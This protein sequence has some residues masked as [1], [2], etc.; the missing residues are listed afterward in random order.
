MGSLRKRVVTDLM[1]EVDGF[2]W[3]APEFANGLGFRWSG[4]DQVATLRIS[5][6]PGC[7]GR[8]E[9]H[10]VGV[11]VPPMSTNVAL[12]L[13][14]HPLTGVA[15]QTGNLVV[16]EAEYTPQMTA[17]DGVSE[18]WFTVAATLPERNAEGAVLRNL[19]IAVSCIIVEPEEVARPV[20]DVAISTL[21]LNAALGRQI[22]SRYMAVLF[23]ESSLNF[24]A[25]GDL[26]EEV[27]V[28]LASVQFGSNELPEVVFRLQ[29]FGEDVMIE[30]RTNDN[31]FIDFS[32]FESVLAE[33]Q[34]GRY[35]KF[36]IN[37]DRLSGG[38]REFLASCSLRNRVFI[39]SLLRILPAVFGRDQATHIDD[40]PLTARWYRVAVSTS[41]AATRE[42]FIL[43]HDPEIDLI[44]AVLG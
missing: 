21:E 20:G 7:P 39:L 38:D 30:I 37:F 29:K 32:G 2:G 8:I 26:Y 24:S 12:Y 34:W 15:R 31:V 43:A 27:L 4:P 35:I 9:V 16:L 41:A 28:R 40:P 3:Y 11:G 18:I 42:L 36:L 1:F 5:I 25:S 23:N 10:V 33:D 22:L 19:G 44:A 13:N 17:I 6:P 14:G